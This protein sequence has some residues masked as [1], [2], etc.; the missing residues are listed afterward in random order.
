MKWK[1]KE[2]NEDLSI[3][4]EQPLDKKMIELMSTMDINN[5]FVNDIITLLNNPHY[6]YDL[7]G[8]IIQFKDMDQASDL[9]QKYIKEHKKIM[10]I[11][12]YDSDGVNAAA[13]AHKFFKDEI[14]KLIPDFVSYLVYVNKPK[15]GYGINKT[16]IDLVKKRYKDNNVDLIITMDHGIVNE[17]A[18]KEIKYACPNLKIIVTD[19]HE[20]QDDLYPV[21]A[22]FVID[23]KRKDNPIQME[24][25]GCLMGFYLLF[26]TH[27]KLL[28]NYNKEVDAEAL[29]DLINTHSGKDELYAELI[30]HLAISLLSDVI[31]VNNIYNRMILKLGLKVLNNYKSKYPCWSTIKDLFKLPD[32][33]ILTEDDLAYKIGPLLNL[34]KRASES[35]LVFNMLISENREK[36]LNSINTL[37]IYNNNRKNITEKVYN[38]IKEN[39]SDNYK[40]SKVALI[41]CEYNIGGNI[42][43]KLSEDYKGVPTICF[44]GNVDSNH[45]EGSGRLSIP[46]IDFMKILK[47][48]EELGKEAGVNIF[49]KYGGHKEAVGVTINASTFSTFKK[50]LDTV[51][52]KYVNDSNLITC[53]YYN[54]EIQPSEIKDYGFIVSELSPYGKNF[55]KPIFRSNLEVKG[56][57]KY[58]TYAILE[59]DIDGDIVTGFY[60]KR[61]KSDELRLKQ[62][63]KNPLNDL[64]GYDR[65]FI[66]TISC[67]AKYN[68]EK[69]E[70][71]NKYS[72]TILDM[73]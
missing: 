5:E 16:I 8:K 50:F 10:V 42:A 41:A 26:V 37:N 70:Y 69:N 22:D 71:T 21:S 47:E 68:K 9:L 34:G 43:S 45:L 63:V 28:Q 65:D 13:I 59:F 54:L 2:K 56:F 3:K 27:I 12:D 19:H 14:S 44:N 72:L 57:R 38:F 64:Y 73:L 1:L 53:K 18:Y 55:P 31:P 30:P 35:D 36:V 58:N 67:Y 66:Y 7:Y 60:P 51:A 11:T 49:V 25:S 48:V 20:I 6:K 23:N 17:K 29:K 61:N 33:K 46:D 52:S 4:S 24:A 39:L 32:E 40:Y 62:F 15:N